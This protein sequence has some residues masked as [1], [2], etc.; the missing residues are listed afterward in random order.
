MAGMLLFALRTTD[1]CT[2]LRLLSSSGATA[3]RSAANASGVTLTQEAE[4]RLVPFSEKSAERKL[5]YYRFSA[6]L[7]NTQFTMNDKPVGIIMLNR[8]NKCDR[9][10]VNNI[11]YFF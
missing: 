6:L 11:K 2:A 8:E 7:G 5:Q 4:N 3:R 9:I 10:S 1:R